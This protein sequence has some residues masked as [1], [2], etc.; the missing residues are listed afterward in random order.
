MAKEEMQ[1]IKEI[2]KSFDPVLV[3]V[4]IGEIGVK[5]KLIDKEVAGIRTKLKKFDKNAVAKVAADYVD[6]SSMAYSCGVQVCTCPEDGGCGRYSIR[7]DAERSVRELGLSIVAAA[8]E[9]D[10][11]TFASAVI[12]ADNKLGYAA[13]CWD[14]VRCTGRQI[15]VMQRCL[16]S[17]YAFDVG[18]EVIDSVDAMLTISKSNP[19]LHK[20]MTKLR[21][22]MKKAG[23]L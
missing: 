12:G 20:R 22:D 8:R 16:A 15:Y 21:E 18:V 23:E 13:L 14:T 6:S 4:A 5:S 19:A 11:N 17:L 9:L 3:A 2:M 1:E 10:E 7:T